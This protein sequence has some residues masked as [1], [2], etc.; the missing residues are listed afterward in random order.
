MTLKY[1][2]KN[3]IDKIINVKG[4][5]ITKNKR[6]MIMDIHKHSNEKLDKML[7]LGLKKYNYY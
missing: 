6:T 5:I 7:N 2:T 3:M 4:H 1:F